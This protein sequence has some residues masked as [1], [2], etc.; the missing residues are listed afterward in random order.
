[1]EST[2]ISS[3]GGVALGGGRT[4]YIGDMQ[5]GTSTITSIPFEISENL[6]AGVYTL[7]LQISGRYEDPTQNYDEKTTTTTLDIPIVVSSNQIFNLDYTETRIEDKEPFK[8]KFIINNFGDPVND[9]YLTIDSPNF[10]NTGSSP[11]YIGD[12]YDSKEVVLDM[13]LDSN[14]LSGRDTIN[15]ILDY[16][17]EMGL[18]EQAVLPLNIYVQKSPEFAIGSISSSPL[19]LISDTSE[20]Q[21]TV[22]L[23]NIGEADAKS[24]N[25]ELVL[26]TGFTE[27]YS[28]SAKDNLGSVSAGQ[29]KIAVYY[30]DIDKG[31]MGGE[32]PA[33]MKIK[34]KEED[35]NEYFEYELPVDIQVVDIPLFEIEAVNISSDNVAPGDEISIKL[36]VKNIGNKQADSVSIR[37]FS[38]QSQ[39]FEFMENSDFIGKLKSGEEGEAILELSI[40]SDAVP[41]DYIIDF[42]I[43]SV[44]DDNVFLSDETLTL[45][46]SE[47]GFNS[48]VFVYLIA[49]IVLL[50]VGVFAGIYFEKRKSKNHNKK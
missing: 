40:D 7:N 15:I 1:V 16:S 27:S 36:K 12:I 4:M 35:S 42:E 26:P 23:E 11:E 46:V 22:E 39:P 44:T 32:Y 2:R 45:T 17:N 34:Y 8:L 6:S 20:A 30:I 24:V 18:K 48:E 28:Y 47:S 14:T 5:P 21:L 19:K 33:V 3:T 25:T 9:A 37:A 49:I 10:L 38:E 50:A 29:S 13:V 41:K 31:I 43:R